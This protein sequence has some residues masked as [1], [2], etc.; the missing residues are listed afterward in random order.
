MQGESASCGKPRGKSQLLL[1]LTSC[2]KSQSC[3]RKCE[4]AD[5][6]CPSLAMNALTANGAQKRDA[7]CAW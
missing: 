1:H 5:G 7:L 3:P 2:V 4:H 6:H